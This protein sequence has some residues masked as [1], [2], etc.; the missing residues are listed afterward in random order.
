MA[1]EKMRDLKK[2]VTT[3][4]VSNRKTE[5]EREY[6][7]N[8]RNMHAK[9]TRNEKQVHGEFGKPTRS[10]ETNSDNAKEKYTHT[11]KW[12][13]TSE[14]K[15]MQSHVTNHKKNANIQCAKTLVVYNKNEVNATK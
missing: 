14:H 8:E 15:E 9:R 4:R 7:D 6:R 10:E 3:C 11:P 1:D 13:T 5:V 2:N 12:R